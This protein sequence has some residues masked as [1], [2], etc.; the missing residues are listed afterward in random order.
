M[1][2]I[3]KVPYIL[4]VSLLLIGGAEAIAQYRET[5]RVPVRISMVT[6]LVKDIPI[7]VVATTAEDYLRLTFGPKSNGHFVTIDSHI[8]QLDDG[9]FKIMT[10]LADETPFLEADGSV[11]IRIVGFNDLSVILEAGQEEVLFSHGER[12]FVIGLLGGTE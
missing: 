9:R 5:Q 6:D 3:K 12:R 1:K 4:V 2:T 10:S 11:G 7:E 8:E